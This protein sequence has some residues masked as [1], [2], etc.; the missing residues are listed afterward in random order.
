VALVAT[1]TFLLINGAD[2]V[3]TQEEKYATF[4]RLMEGG[5]SEGELAAWIRARLSR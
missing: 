4:L 2:L 5:L 3:A 1:R